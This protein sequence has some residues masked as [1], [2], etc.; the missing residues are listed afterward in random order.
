MFSV[1][2]LNKPAGWTSRRAVDAVKYMVRPIKVG[3]AGTLDPLASGV[4]P[5][6]LGPATRLVE[7]A[8]RLPKQ[9]RASFRLG[10]R[11]ASDD[12]ESPLEAVEASSMPT[13]SQLRA[14]L[15]HFQGDVVQRPPRHSAVKIDG[16]R[17][18]R[19]ARREAEFETRERTVRID[20]L[21]L[22]SFEPPNFVFD[23]QCST[24]TYVRSV[25]RDLAE[26]LGTGA[27]MTALTR[28]SVGPLKIE[29]AITPNELPAALTKP[30]LDPSVLLASMQRVFVSS[31]EATDIGFGRPIR[32]ASLAPVD[33][34]VAALDSNGRLLA[35]LKTLWPDL[36]FPVRNFLQLA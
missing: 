31:T 10:V 14:A 2:N 27:V 18:Y 32:R 12:I 19:L 30:L 15:A 7:Y 36:W 9:Y 1:I 20:R 3:H 22:V 6:C 13:E 35:I 24:G 34:E 23:I 17:A 28:T 16:Q 11:S 26:S 21:E 4:L 33:A 25:G 29:D 5:L 8:H